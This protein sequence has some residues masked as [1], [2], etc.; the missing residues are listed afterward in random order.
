M[1]KR[2]KRKAKRAVELVPELV[3]APPMKKVVLKARNFRQ[4]RLLAALKD[5]SQKIVF[6]SGP[7][8]T[9]KTYVS[10]TFAVQQ[11]QE[12]NIKRLVITRPA[13]S[14]DEQHGFLPGTIEDK[15]A[16][17][18]GPI[19]DCLGEYYRPD[20]I[21]QLIQDKVIEIAPLAYMR[22][23]TFKDAII[24]LD[25]SQNTTPSQMQMITTRIGEGSRLFVT[26]DGAQFDRGYEKNGLA[27][28]IR[29]IGQAPSN[30]IA[31]IKF[32]EDE[33][34]RSEIVAEMVQI[35]NNNNNPDA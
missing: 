24:I 28:I 2:E 14:V 9:G 1:T 19:L 17:W 23:R 30:L 13:V 32:T 7:A 12:K 27:D 10:T 15:M 35:Y 3:K 18:L 29:R 4:R 34:E 6:A 11:L 33:V 21:K 22:G 26:G 20:E 8:G 31:H 25:E 16:P 5:D